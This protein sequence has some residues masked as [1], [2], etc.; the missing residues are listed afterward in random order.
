MFGRFPTSAAS[1]LPWPL[2]PAVVLAA[3]RDV[4]DPTERNASSHRAT[5]R[6]PAAKR[7]DGPVASSR[8]ARDDVRPW[9]DQADIF[10]G[11]PNRRTTPWPCSSHRLSGR[12][13]RINRPLIAAVR[14]DRLWWPA[15]RE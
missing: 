2:L 9:L 1:L 10:V 11:H 15:R 4:C 5:G 12:P 14:A 6:H 13:H 3:W 8:R 7:D